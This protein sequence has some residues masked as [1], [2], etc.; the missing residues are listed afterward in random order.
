[1]KKFLFLAMT[2]LFLAACSGNNSDNATDQNENSQNNN[3]TAVEE[4]G[5]FNDFAEFKT[6]TD[7]IGTNYNVEV[8]E[9]TDE[10]RILTFKNDNDEEVYQSH[11]LKQNNLLKITNLQEDRLIFNKFFKE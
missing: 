1:M 9:D 7:Q 4:N 6:V 2:V 8:V 5:E 10:N 11:Y 3:E